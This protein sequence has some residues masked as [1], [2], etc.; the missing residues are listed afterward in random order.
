MINHKVK[1]S[2]FDY[3]LYFDLC[4]NHLKIQPSEAWKM[5]Y[6]EVANLVTRDVPQEIDLSF[7]LN[8]QRKENGGDLSLLNH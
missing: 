7:M 5:D 3:W 6:V 8:F 1:P 4:V 2:T